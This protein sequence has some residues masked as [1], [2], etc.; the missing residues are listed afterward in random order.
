MSIKVTIKGK[1][2][3][4][5]HSFKAMK[6]IKEASGLN[7]MESALQLSGGDDMPDFVEHILACSIDCDGSFDRYAE[8]NEFIDQEGFQVSWMMAQ[9]ILSGGMIGSV[10][11]S[12]IAKETWLHNLLRLTGISPLMS[13]RKQLF[14][15]ILL[16]LIFGNSIWMIFSA[17]ER[18][19]Y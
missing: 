11:K 14:P 19:S 9:E 5:E 7:L 6:A 12:Q 15:W 8:A 1:E 3:K 10:K 18:F 16:L 17:I 2:R 4:F 13:L